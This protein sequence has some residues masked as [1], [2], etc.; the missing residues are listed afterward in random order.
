[1]V[2]KVHLPH[3][4][5]PTKEC[6]KNACFHH[7]GFVNAKFCLFTFNAAEKRFVFILVELMTVNNLKHNNDPPIS[8]FFLMTPS[9]HHMTPLSHDIL[10]LI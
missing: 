9:P 3:T 2:I 8:T 5:P 1:M 6:P 4:L 10:S 7:F